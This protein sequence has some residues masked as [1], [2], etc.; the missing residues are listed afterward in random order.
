MPI[1]V[2][3]ADD[4]FFFLV[5]FADHFSGT[6]PL[7]G[8][9]QIFPLLPPSPK[10]SCSRRLVP[11]LPPPTPASLL[12][13]APVGNGALSGV[14]AKTPSDCFS[15]HPWLASW[16]AAF[17]HIPA[18]DS[19]RLQPVTQRACGSLV[20]AL[21]LG[22]SVCVVWSAPFRHAV[23]TS[24]SG[25]RGVTRVKLLAPTKL[26]THLVLR[27]PS[28]GLARPQS[29]SY[30][31]LHT[32]VSLLRTARLQSES[33]ERRIT[34]PRPVSRVQRFEHGV[35]RAKQHLMP[36]VARAAGQRFAYFDSCTPAWGY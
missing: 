32:P 16:R 12:P 18:G 9:F 4:D 35:S 5:L 10:M 15:V 26:F 28:H 22:V 14:S 31:V 20:D 1:I 29:T 21:S 8:V 7:F 36:G 11:S 33:R 25:R 24:T 34:R 13:R 23:T 19:P 30:S 27:A 6:S 2:T 17:Q 3:L